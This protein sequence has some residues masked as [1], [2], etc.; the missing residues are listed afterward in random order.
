MVGTGRPDQSVIS[1]R[2]SFWGKWDNSAQL[3]GNPGSVLRSNRARFA[4]ATVTD[5]ATH[6]PIAPFPF[7]HKRTKGSSGFYLLRQLNIYHGCRLLPSL[8]CILPCSS[9][10][11]FMKLEHNSTPSAHLDS[12]ICIL[13]LLS[14]DSSNSR[15]RE[16]W[17]NSTLFLDG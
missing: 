2:N 14:P 17:H 11:L 7:A 16:T 8:L 1:P 4:F 15:Q 3:S 10:K 5:S 6:G 9:L 13:A 12:R